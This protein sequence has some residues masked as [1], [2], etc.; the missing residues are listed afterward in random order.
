LAQAS[1]CDR[2][3]KKFKLVS[4]FLTTMAF[5]YVLNE[6]DFLEY[7][8]FIASGSS[9]IKKL[10]LRNWLVVSGCFLLL[11][12]LF[13]QTGDKLLT[14]YFLAIGVISLCFYPSYQKWHYKNRYQ[15]F[16]ADTYKNRIGQAVHVNFMEDWIETNDLYCES[17]IKLNAIENIT[18]TSDYFYIKMKTGG[19]LIIPKSKI[20]NLSSVEGRLKELCTKLS[21]QFICDLKWR[22]K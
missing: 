15:K 20:D 17:K 18:E 6:N 4:K 21:I 2:I 10:R 16:I 14:Y 5:T 1:A 3:E 22:G 19:H 13:Y 7:Q 9:R 12:L 8:L 11:S